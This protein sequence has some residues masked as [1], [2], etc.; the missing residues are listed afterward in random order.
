MTAASEKELNAT[1]AFAYD[2][3]D[4]REFPQ[5]IKAL[6]K[7]LSW[8][9]TLYGEGSALV[10][11]IE[12]RLGDCYYRMQSYPEAVEHLKPVYERRL[13]YK[14][15]MPERVVTVATNYGVSLASLGRH[16]EAI[17][18]LTIALELCSAHYGADSNPAW[19]MRNRLSISL[20]AAEQWQLLIA[21][22]QTLNHKIDLNEGNNR[23]FMLTI[24]RNI[25]AGYYRTGAAEE[26]LKLLFQALQMTKEHS[27][28]ASSEALDDLEFAARVLLKLWR[29]DEATMLLEKAVELSGSMY[30]DQ[31]GRCK[32]LL[33]Q[34]DAVNKTIARRR[35]HQARVAEQA[36]G[37]ALTDTAVAVY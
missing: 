21:F 37:K 12:R 26:A 28:L 31:S 10:L 32:T 16:N 27:S 4:R 24:L 17:P 15:T 35:A 18:V 11:G 3:M 6:L 14:S 7:C 13:R 25:A 23:Q 34:L 36:T 1:L 29:H 20:R 33:L 2:F 9:K 30:G 22:H 5:A 8:S 19:Y